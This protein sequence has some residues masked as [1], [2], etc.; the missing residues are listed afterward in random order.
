MSM[1]QTKP[2]MNTMPAHHGREKGI[3]MATLH[4]RVALVTGAG[5]GIGAAEAVRLAQPG[6]PYPSHLLLPDS[7]GET[8]LGHR[9]VRN[10]PHVHPTTVGRKRVHVCEEA[11]QQWPHHFNN[12]ARLGKAHG[13]TAFNVA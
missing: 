10:A 1:R 5:R 6:S 7:C 9:D 3:S 8:S 4:E 13:T 12:S 11:P 2:E